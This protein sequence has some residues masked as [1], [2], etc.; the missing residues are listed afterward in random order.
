MGRKA[1]RLIEGRF[2]FQTGTSNRDD[3]VVQFDVRLFLRDQKLRVSFDI[4]G[5]EG[6]A[7]EDL[8]PALLEA[9][10]A[11]IDLVKGRVKVSELHEQVE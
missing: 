3:D 9:I 1:P 7:V 6:P 10:K 4:H 5:A 8:D 2:T 11:A